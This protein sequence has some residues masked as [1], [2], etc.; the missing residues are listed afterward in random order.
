[1]MV[2]S[3]HHLSGVYKILYHFRG[4][5]TAVFLWKRLPPPPRH[6]NVELSPLAQEVVNELSTVSLLA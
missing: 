1:M 4:K 2:N 3:A 5:S 6:K